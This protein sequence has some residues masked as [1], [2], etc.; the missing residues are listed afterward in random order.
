MDQIARDKKLLLDYE[1]LRARLDIR[2]FFL[3]HTVREVYENIGQVL[4]VVRM[5]LAVL[6]VDDKETVRKMPTANHLVGETIRELRTMCS[7]F[8]PDSDIIRDE[9]FIEGFNS[10]I[11][12]LYPDTTVKAQIR[13][14]RKEIQ[15]Q[16]ILI[17]FKLIKEVLM[18]IKEAEADLAKFSISYSQNH[19][20]WIVDYVGKE[21]QLMPESSEDVID[22][23]LALGERAELIGG[24]ITVTTTKTAT[25]RIILISPYKTFSV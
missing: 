22:R 4:S 23:P 17:I 25:Y 12:I 6:D 18:I 1:V 8:Y 3:K 21:I 9:G 24:R 10:I 2:D 20:N 14:F 15:P 19:V 16:L 5:Q 11:R 7:N 13:G